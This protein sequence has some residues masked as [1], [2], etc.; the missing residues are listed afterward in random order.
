MSK[1]A[2][3]D[4]I[5]EETLNNTNFRKVL[6]TGKHM[7]LVLMSLKP[8]EDIGSE[9]HHKVD[10]FI[11]IDKG[12]G[13]SVLNGEENEL[14]DGS[15]IVV[16]AG[17]EHNIVNTSETEE[18]KLYTVYAPANHIDGRVHVTKEDAIKD[19]EDEHFGE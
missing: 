17:I 4:N 10:Q 6:Y 19:E 7:Q 15:A 16:P 12:E 2:Y 5:E 14:K 13:K 18:M 9:V 1:V 3:V 11:R 8:G